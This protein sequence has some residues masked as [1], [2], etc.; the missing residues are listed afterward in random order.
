MGGA[1]SSSVQ[2]RRMVHVFCLK[3]QIPEMLARLHKKQAWE[4]L[5]ELEIK[6]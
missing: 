6:F 3:G 4:G 1:M 5:T 2:N